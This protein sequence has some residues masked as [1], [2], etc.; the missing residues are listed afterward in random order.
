MGKIIFYV[1][2][3]LDSFLADENG[4]VDWLLPFQNESYDYGYAGFLKTIGYVVSGSKTYEQA[5]NFPGGWNFPNTK[6]Y[7]FT[8]RDLDSEG[9]E[10]IVPWQGGAEELAAILRSEQKNTWLLGGAALAANF[11][12]ERLVDELILTQIPVVLSRGKPLFEGIDRRLN[13]Q[14]QRVEHFPNGVVQMTYWL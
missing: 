11:F 2:A 1:A 8:S 7:I 5:K 10:D 9:R 6:S 13:L 12:N 3:S 14:L 4:S